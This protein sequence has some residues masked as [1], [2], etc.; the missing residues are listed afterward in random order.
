MGQK[1][2]LHARKKRLMYE[3][4]SQLLS[5]YGKD[6]RGK[7]QVITIL[8]DDKDATLKKPDVRFPLPTRLSL[9]SCERA[10]L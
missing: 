1:P 7:K 10:R 8:V 5:V 4:V 2:G 3:G 9:C 6:E